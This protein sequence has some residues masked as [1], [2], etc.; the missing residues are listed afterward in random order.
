[1]STSGGVWDDEKFV[2]KPGIKD[3][4]ARGA[5]MTLSF[6]PQFPTSATAIGLVQTVKTIK[7]GELFFLGNDTIAARSL[8]GGEGVGTSIDQKPNSGNP[9]Y[10]TP[11]VEG[12]ENDLAF[13]ENGYRYVEII[14]GTIY[15][16]VKKAW[17]RDVPHL[18]NLEVGEKASSQVFEVTAL[19]L[20]GN[21]KGAYYGS[22]RW[23]WEL[24]EGGEH[25]LIPL[26]VVS[27]GNPSA[28][29]MESAKLWN[30]T[31]TSA[32]KEPKQL[33]VVE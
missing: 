16:R 12:E 3:K 1:M 2:L 24:T 22:V 27:Q 9:V 28:T 15:E 29:F 31:A 30:K 5:D 32:G 20:A 19:A 8:T 11:D 13:G 26:Q 14:K 23:G 18:R 17:L 7:N 33:P 21:Q 25:R 4:T 10:A 6:T